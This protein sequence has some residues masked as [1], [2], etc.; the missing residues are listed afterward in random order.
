MLRA[1][2]LFLD[3]L[4]EIFQ[5][6]YFWFNLKDGVIPLFNNMVIKLTIVSALDLIHHNSA[7]TCRCKKPRLP[8]FVIE[9]NPP[10][11]IAVLPKY[12]EVRTVEPR[13]M[14][15]NIPL[16]KAHTICQGR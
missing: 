6:L 9:N 1:G 15:Q 14:I 10:Y 7:G 8:S 5:F 11:V 2:I 13:L 3:L 16:S 12:V 4:W